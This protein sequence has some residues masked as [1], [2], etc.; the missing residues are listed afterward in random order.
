MRKAVFMENNFYE[1]ILDSMDDAIYV[2]DNQGN[3]IFVN[4]AYVRQL[5]M[6]KSELLR[7]NVHDFLSTGQISE[8]IFDIVIREHCQVIRFQDVFDT[9]N[10]GR[11]SFRQLVVMTPF[12]DENGAISN[13]QATLRPLDM[14]NKEYFAASRN[15]IPLQKSI[16]QNTFSMPNIVAESDAMKKVLQM[17]QSIS[18]TDASVLITGESG[19]GK[20]VV[21]HYIHNNGL[22]SK[23]PLVIINCASLPENLLEAELFGY[24]KGAFTGAAPG[25]KKGLIEEA[26]GGTLFLD[27]INSLPLALQGKLLRVIETKTIQ[28]LGG[29]KTK[30]VDFRLIVTTNEDL[31]MLVARKSFRADLFYRINVIPINLPPLRERRQDIVP[32]AI[33]FLEEFCKKNR[34]SKS[35]SP[36][37]LKSMQQYDWPGNV[38]ELK[39]FVERAVLLSTE[40]NIKIPNI[41]N[42]LLA[43]EIEDTNAAVGWPL[44]SAQQFENLVE[45]GRRLQDY[46]DECESNIIQWAL[47][48]YGSTYKAAEALGTSQASIMRKKKKYTTAA[49]SNNA[50]D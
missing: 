8:C 6:S 39:N 48:K 11:P 12:F 19:T 28:R 45:D 27:E 24:E 32:L 40:Q 47:E 38:R 46:L 41:D 34:K 25:G 7:M 36:H 14:L 10:V 37:I 13:V 15:D 31:K 42:F 29:Y 16:A 30:K 35:F 9:Q 17:A 5:Q 20:D 21:A 23:G 1:M 3:F 4:S 43:E 49:T 18:D 33:R 22:R 2:L 26:D 44:E 50:P